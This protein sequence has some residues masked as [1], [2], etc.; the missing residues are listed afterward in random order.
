ML[1]AGASPLFTNWQHDQTE[2]GGRPGQ[3]TTNFELL[4]AVTR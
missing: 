1:V 3:A 4:Q 2:T